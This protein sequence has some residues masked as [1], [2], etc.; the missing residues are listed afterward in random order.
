MRRKYRSRRRVS[1]SAAALAFTSEGPQAELLVRALQP[2]AEDSPY[3]GTHGFHP[4]PGRFHP[5]LPRT[6][7]REFAEGRDFSILDPFMGG[8]TTLVEA[9]AQGH[10]AYGS[11]LNP[12]AVGIAKERT[13]R[14][15]PEEAQRAL[16]TLAEMGRQVIAAKGRG[17]FDPKYNVLRAYHPPH[18]FAELT[19][20]C[21]RCERTQN[22]DIRETLRMVFSSAV[23]KFADQASDSRPPRFPRGSSVRASS[24]GRSASEESSSKKSAAA[25]GNASS[26]A[27][28]HYP[29]GAV[30]AFICDKGRQLIE[31]QGA[32][33]Q[34]APPSAPTPKCVAEDARLLRGLAQ[35]APFDL[36][37][38]SPPYP[39]VYDY[40]KQHQ[41]RMRWLNLDARPLERGEIGARRHGHASSAAEN[42]RRR[43]GGHRK[44]EP[45]KDRPGTRASK[46]NA[47]R[48]AGKA[49]KKF[50]WSADMRTVFHRWTTLLK[51]E[52]PLFMLMGDW[53][54]RDHPV[55]AVVM[56]QRLAAPSGWKLVARASV[57]RPLHTFREKRCFAARGKWEHLLRFEREESP[58]PADCLP[59]DP[60]DV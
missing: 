5:H 9:L 6:L 8:G 18:L 7:L 3:Q 32:L 29:K 45:Q 25:R 21:M 49:E 23:V 1:L 27:G 13:R 2:A 30:T 36:I 4:Y 22:E 56:L 33:Y 15:S 60:L 16:Q 54:N 58:N 46:A 51:P 55:D 53:Q 19:Q 35:D 17:W 38:T 43:K 59:R 28:V 20:W 14:R 42:A 47:S 37:L 40:S 12:I 41:L 31:A 44:G 11:D 24:S 26:A 57:Q 10:T 39:G 50:S 34:Q 48:T 52:A